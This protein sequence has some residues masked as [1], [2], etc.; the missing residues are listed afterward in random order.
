ME[1]KAEELRDAY[2]RGINAKAHEYANNENSVQILQHHM[3][4]AILD[5][6]AYAYVSNVNPQTPEA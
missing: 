2:L 3:M 1:K 5:S 4:A 6:I